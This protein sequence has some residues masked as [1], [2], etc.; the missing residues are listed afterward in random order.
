MSKQK[1]ENDGLILL[2]FLGGI[3]GLSVG[4][5]YTVVFFTAGNPVAALGL[6]V[7]MVTGLIAL[8]QIK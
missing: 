2:G 4:I 7:A 8:G 1:L 3:I 6:I 5:T